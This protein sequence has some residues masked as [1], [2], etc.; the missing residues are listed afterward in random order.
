MSDYKVELSQLKI[1]KLE[2]MV[3]LEEAT[4]LQ[5]CSQFSASIFEPNDSAD[6]T[7]LVKV[8]C[9]FKDATEKMLKVTCTADLFFKIDPIPED[10]VEILIQNTRDIVQKKLTERVTTILNNMGHKIALVES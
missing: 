9:S 5:M 2:V 10:R 1:N 4:A 7:A 3:T 8:D 6:P